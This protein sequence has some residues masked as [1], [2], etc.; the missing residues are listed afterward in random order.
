MVCIIGGVLIYAFIVGKS[1]NMLADMDAGERDKMMKLEVR[2]PQSVQ[3]IDETIGCTS[4]SELVKRFKR[5][6]AQTDPQLLRLCDYES[7]FGSFGRG[8]FSVLPYPCTDQV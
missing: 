1:T 3:F 7:K 6:I 2:V 8:V 5:S 4:L